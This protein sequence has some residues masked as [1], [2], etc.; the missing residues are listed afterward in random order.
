GLS[1]PSPSGWLCWRPTALPS[2][3]FAPKVRGREPFR[4]LLPRRSLISSM[5][6]SSR[7]RAVAASS[8]LHFLT[9][10]PDFCV[11][12]K[13]GLTIGPGKRRSNP[14]G[15]PNDR[16][17]RALIT[18]V[19]PLKVE[20]VSVVDANACHHVGSRAPKRGFGALVAI[21]VEE[22]DLFARQDHGLV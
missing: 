4:P 9:Q 22:G 13:D 21:N 1:C 2:A 19:G 6:L 16:A 15:V 3:F 8:V 11:A 20:G 14:A 17:G 10:R 12:P 7:R 5:R 18:Q